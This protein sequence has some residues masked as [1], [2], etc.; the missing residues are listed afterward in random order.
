MLYL[1]FDEFVYSCHALSLVFMNSICTT[2][3]PFPRAREVSSMCTSVDTEKTLCFVVLVIILSPPQCLP[4]SDLL[5]QKLC[6][7]DRYPLPKSGRKPADNS[8][9]L[10]SCFIQTNNKWLSCGVVRWKI[11]HL[12]LVLTVMKYLIFECTEHHNSTWHMIL[13]LPDVHQG[14]V[15]KPVKVRWVSFASN[16]TPNPIL[17]PRATRDNGHAEP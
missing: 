6:S 1:L 8:G 4:V 17:Y 13:I 5:S 15:P 10:E 3:I 14:S 11:F 9:K 7:K 12:Y 2:Y 16:L